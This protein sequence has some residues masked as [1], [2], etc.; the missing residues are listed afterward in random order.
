MAS[1][2]GVV[3]D[4]RI[5]VRS[6]ESSWVGGGA[7]FWLS[8]RVAD[9]EVDR[10]RRALNRNCFRSARGGWLDR[11]EIWLLGARG[12]EMIGWNRLSVAALLNDGG[13]EQGLVGKRTA[14]C[15]G[16]TG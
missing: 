6:F 11:A 14:N 15:G 13:V 16:M 7:Y 10:S 9:F 3:Y 4:G 2:W 5:F 1:W 12:V 8:R